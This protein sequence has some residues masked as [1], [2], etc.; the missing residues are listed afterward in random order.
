MNRRMTVEEKAAVLLLTMDKSTSAEVLKNMSEEHIQRIAFRMAE[1]KTVSQA[2]RNSVLK[3]FY[4]LCLEEGFSVGGGGLEYAKEILTE[5]LGSQRCVEIISK[6]SSFIKSKPFDFLKKVDANE[7]IDFLRSERNQTVALILSF[8]DPAQGSVILNSFDEERQTDIIIRVAKM[9]KI[10]PEIVN[11]VEREVKNK[12][13]NFFGETNS[14]DIVGI[15]IAA[16]IL[17]SI[18]R[19]TKVSIFDKMEETNSELAEELKKRMFLFEDIIRLDRRHAQVVLSR[20]QNSDLAMALKSTSERMKTFVFNNISE[21]AQEIIR[22]EMDMLGRIRL[23]EVL[24]AQQKIVAIV[25][26]MEQNQEIIITKD[27]SDKLV[28]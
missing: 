7:I 3:E 14:T 28:G 19:G 4:Q 2:M 6:M 8:L 16:E 27:A 1:N 22:Q 11:Q 9:S 13:S 12:I 26:E 17:S 15:N 25:H 20:V 23:S 24:E 21:R 5:A 18:D 10:S